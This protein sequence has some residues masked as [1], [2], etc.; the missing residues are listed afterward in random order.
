[1]VESSELDSVVIAVE[2][3]IFAGGL[4]AT[5]VTTTAGSIGVG[6]PFPSS[7]SDNSKVVDGGITL[8][9]LGDPETGVFFRHSAF[10]FF[11]LHSLL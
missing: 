4:E 3:I 7:V 8:L 10:F 9:I 11:L 1:M 6:A 2:C 5:D